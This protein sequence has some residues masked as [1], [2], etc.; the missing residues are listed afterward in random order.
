VPVLIAAVLVVALVVVGG[1]FVFVTSKS[2]SSSPSSQ[3]SIVAV[4]PARSATPTV[5]ITPKSKGGTLTGKVTSEAGSAES[6]IGVVLC[7]MSTLNCITDSHLKAVSSKDGSFEIDNIPAGSYAVFYSTT[8][9]V[10]ASDDNLTINVNDNSA[11]CIG[12]ALQGG[13]N[14]TASCFS[15]VPFSEDDPNTKVVKNSVVNQAADGT[16]RLDTGAIYSPLYGLTLNF[17]N[18]QPLTVA[19]AAGSATKVSIVVHPSV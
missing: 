9:A 11:G 3:A 7:A 1:A 2:S 19:V 12:Q 17:A 4:E 5:L 16:Y 8:G 15:S 14:V 10:P 13:G 6:G 18:G